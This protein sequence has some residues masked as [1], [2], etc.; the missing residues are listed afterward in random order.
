M[1]VNLA[2]NVDGSILREAFLIELLLTS[3]PCKLYLQYCNAV[4]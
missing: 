1:R 2:D 3:S 4:L